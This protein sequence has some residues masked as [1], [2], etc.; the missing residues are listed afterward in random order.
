M[1]PKSNP[2]QGSMQF[3][4]RK[5]AKQSHARIRSWATESKVKPLGFVGYKAGMAHVMVTDNRPKSLTKEE[6]ISLPVTI[7][8]CPA[9]TVAGVCFYKKGL[10]GREKCSTILAEK[11]SKDLG[12][13]IALPKKTF[14]KVDDI[15]ECD[16][17]RLLVHSNPKHTSIGAKKPVLVEIAL[18]GPVEE[19]RAYAKDM[20]GKDIS[21]SDIF[22]EGSLLDVHGITK[23][24]GFQGVVKR[25][26]VPILQHKGEKA[27][28][29]IG[30]LGSWTPKR[31]EFTVAQPGKMG[32]HTRTQYNNQILKIGTDGKEITP[33]SGFGRYG[34]VKNNYILLHGS[35]A[36]SVKRT[37]ILTAAIRPPRKMHKDAFSI[38]F[39]STQK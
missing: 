21:L 13:L 32:Y 28:R 11:L 36:G 34:I 27:K 9:M 5:R 15:Q 25:Y 39:V 37:V 35:V 16:D 33:K 38:E 26:G 29:S 14:K 18:G 20:L 12:R 3:W 19:K 10:L 6:T 23:G 7:I 31:V 22:E 2:R 17:I 1:P 8:D 30:N 24:K 4:P